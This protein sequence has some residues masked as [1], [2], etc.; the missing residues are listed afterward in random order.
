[1]PENINEH[2][3]NLSSSTFGNQSMTPHASVLYSRFQPSTEMPSVIRVLIKSHVVKN[4]RQAQRLI[5]TV[6]LLF[7][8]AAIVFYIL[9]FQHSSVV[10]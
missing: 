6:V 10:I 1:M 5:L 4:E 9:S 8:I 2:E 3:I 7:V